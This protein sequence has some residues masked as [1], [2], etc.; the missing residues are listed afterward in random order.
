MSDTFSDAAVIKGVHAYQQGLKGVNTA[1]AASRLY[2]RQ[3]I[4]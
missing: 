1:L 4:V 2:V 3:V